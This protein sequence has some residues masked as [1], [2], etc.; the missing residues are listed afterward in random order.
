MS[1]DLSI[2]SIIRDQLGGR[3]FEVMTGAKRFVAIASGLQ[4]RLPDNAKDGINCVEITLTPA[5]L[6]DVSY[7][8][9]RGAQVK[10]ISR[11]ENIYAE[12]L[13]S[14]FL[15]ATGLFTSLGQTR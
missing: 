10:E 9:V 12:D 4:F 14:S 2:A 13:S 11:D 3:R 1:E 15:K 5:D 6:Y 7:L 8:N